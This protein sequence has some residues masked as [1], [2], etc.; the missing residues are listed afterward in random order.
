[1]RREGGLDMGRLNTSFSM[2]DM[3]DKTTITLGRAGER[4]GG[5]G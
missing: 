2:S 4:R 5:T 1:M 3:M